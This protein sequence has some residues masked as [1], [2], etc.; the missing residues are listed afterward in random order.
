[1]STFAFKNNDGYWSTRYSFS[2]TNYS[3]INRDM[4]TAP[5]SGGGQGTPALWSHEPKNNAVKTSYYGSPA[6]GSSMKFSFNENVSANKIYKNFSLEG[7]FE[8]NSPSASFL[9]NDSSNKNQQR[10]AT[11]STFVQ[12]GAML[13]SNIG[14]NEYMTRANITPVGQ[15]KGCWQ[16]YTPEAQSINVYQNKTLPTVLM[17][18]AD[19]EALSQSSLAYLKNQYN[20]NPVGGSYEATEIDG[21]PRIYDSTRSRYA[22]LH[23]DFF[24]NYQPSSS[25]TKY[26]V[27]DAL[28]VNAFSKY[29]NK[30]FDKVDAAFNSFGV[31]ESGEGM[32]FDIKGSPSK[33]K[34]KNKQYEWRSYVDEP[35]NYDALG[36]LKDGYGE[37]LDGIFCVRDKYNNTPITLASDFD[38]DGLV[39]TNDLLMFL[40]E[41]GLEGEGIP[42]D[43]NND[44]QVT[45]TDLLEFLTDFGGG[46][47]PN[48]G[49]A[50]AVLN[51]TASSPT[52]QPITVYAVTP[53]SIDGESARGNYADMSLSL[54]GDFE[55]DVVNLEYEPTTL[56][57]SR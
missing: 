36:P 3:L 37:Y 50:L 44:G 12:K 35:D 29:F 11:A 13:H 10:P 47:T 31:L 2:P 5:K 9:A 1:M 51:T 14:K 20:V 38:S 48:I 17:D 39:T 8:N 30:T 16:I 42:A 7:S 28:D 4:I 34:F 55:L 32:T 6:A 18:A 27:S 24:S 15:L 41:F 52:D 46:A 56:D 49:A 23:I 22:F 21:T 33:V 40:G 57:H 45:I 19:A 53:G 43:L 26:I 25:E 54:Q